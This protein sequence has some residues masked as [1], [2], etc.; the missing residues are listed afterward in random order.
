MIREEGGK[1]TAYLPRK[2][3]RHPARPALHVSLRSPAEISVEVAA[4]N[5]WPRKNKV[6]LKLVSFFLYHVDR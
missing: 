1:S 2:I 6:I 4:A 5:I 3:H